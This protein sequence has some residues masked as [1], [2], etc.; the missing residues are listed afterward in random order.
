MAS[1]TN[2]PDPAEMRRERTARAAASE[3]RN[4][5]IQ[6]ALMSK[7]MDIVVTAITQCHANNE[8]MCTKTPDR[9]RPPYH[10]LDK[11]TQRML[12]PELD[13]PIAAMLGPKLDGHIATH[14]PTSLLVKY[15]GEKLKERS[16]LYQCIL[17]MDHYYMCDCDAGQGCTEFIEIKWE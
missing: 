14:L 2:I 4:Q 9:F 8:T 7:V 12:G 17:K 3:A 15:I 10:D 13:G 11:E 5:A 1:P 16:P 6:Q